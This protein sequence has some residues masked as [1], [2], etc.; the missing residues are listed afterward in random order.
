[1]TNELLPQFGGWIAS[2][3]I[4]VAFD[5]FKSIVAMKCMNIRAKRFF[6]GLFWNNQEAIGEAIDKFSE[7]IQ[8]PEFSEAIFNAYRSACMTRSRKFGPLLIGLAA[9]EFNAIGCLPEYAFDVFD[10]L[11]MVD[12]EDVRA[13]D[14]FLSE[15]I[16]N[17]KRYGKIN[18]ESNT[19]LQIEWSR[20]SRVNSGR[21]DEELIVSPMDLHVCIGR[22][23][24]LCQRSNLM[25]IDVVDKSTE[26]DDDSHF[27]DEPGVLREIIT[28][29]TISK[30]L[31][32]LQ[33]FIKQIQGSHV[34]TD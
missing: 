30:H 14:D 17:K 10:L 21:L 25:R 2:K 28:Y 26:F 31:F 19:E 1:M 29:L 24:S 22:W 11:E 23:A 4:D 32:E 9:S 20:D 27:A 13:M 18:F 3:A 5:H 15:I 33:R 7:K 16:T 8:D 34:W 12:D 6:E